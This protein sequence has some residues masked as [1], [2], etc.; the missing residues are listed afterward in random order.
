MLFSVSWQMTKRSSISVRVRQIMAAVTGGC[1]SFP[2][3]VLIR[4]HWGRP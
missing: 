3:Q 1:F 2:R 4:V